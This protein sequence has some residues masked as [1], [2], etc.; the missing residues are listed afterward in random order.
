MY[1]KRWKIKEN[2]IKVKDWFKR[3]NVQLGVPEREKGENRREEIITKINTKVSHD[4]GT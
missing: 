3:S 2:V 1:S 4:E